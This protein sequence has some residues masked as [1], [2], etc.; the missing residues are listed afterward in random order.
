MNSNFN[1]SVGTDHERIYYNCRLDNQIDNVSNSATE[2]AVYNKQSQNILENQS[3][4]EMAVQSYGIRAKL[5]I[6]V[7]P[8][9]QGVNTDINAMPYSVC[10]SYTNPFVPGSPRQDFKKDVV[11]APDQAFA[12]FNPNRVAPLPKSPAENNGIQDFLTSPNYYYCNSYKSFLDMVNLALREAWVDFNAAVPGV[13]AEPVWVQY[14]ARTGLFAFVGPY[15]MTGAGG[16]GLNRAAVTMD[17]LLYKY[18]DGIESRF[19]GYNTSNGRDYEIVFEQFPGQSN[20]WSLGNHYAGVVPNVTTNPPAYLIMEQETDL[21][22]LWNN[23]KQIIISTESINVRTEFMPFIEFPQQI[24]KAI[25]N[26][27]NQ[28]RKSIISYEDYNVTGN[29]W[30]PG[31]HRDIYYEPYFYKWIDLI[32]DSVLNNIQIEIFFQTEEGVTLP[33]NIPRNGVC[34]VKLAF[35]KKN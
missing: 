2:I 9:I 34:N 33:L 8:I 7:A 21:R 26:R 16:V 10:Y 23:I 30:R 27:F 12:S 3:D 11:W 13:H 5:P 14:D 18:F 19:N 1:Q 28:P 22:H 29:N 4:Y 15:S 20:Y 24:N 6:F 32:S 35:R 25:N 17:A 31:I